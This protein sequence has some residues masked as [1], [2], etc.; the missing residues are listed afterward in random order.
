MNARLVIP[1]LIAAACAVG[2]F[3]PAANAGGLF[4][5]GGVIR[6]DVGTFMQKNVQEP[7]LTPAARG[8]VTT[9]TTAV[10]GVVG[11]VIG[12][13]TGA[14][15]GGF[16]GK[17]VGDEINRR[18]AGQGNPIGRPTQYPPQQYDAPVLGNRCATQVGIFAPGPWDR[19]GAPCHGNGP[20]GRVFGQVIQ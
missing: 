11:G 20:Y 5:E 6:G 4:G 9:T 18:A 1:T 15:I 2:G 8:A 16:G 14:T 13:P 3:S 17:Q 10:G 12:G 19:V 7:I